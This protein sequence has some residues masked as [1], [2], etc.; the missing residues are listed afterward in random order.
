[1]R[2]RERESERESERVREIVLIELHP[3]YITSNL[4][5]LVCET[6]VSLQC[7]PCMRIDMLQY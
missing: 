2:E 1:M 5:G 3:C 7:V 4:R 6:S